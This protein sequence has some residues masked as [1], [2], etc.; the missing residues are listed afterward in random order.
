MPKR[1]ELTLSKRTVDRLSV[2]GKDAVFWDRVL[3]GFGVRVYP[4]GRKIYVV[5]TRGAGGLKRVSLGRHG[6]LTAERARKEAAA[7]IDRIKL[8]GKPEAAP[9][10]RPLTVADLAERY[11]EAHVAANCNAHT[12]GIYRGSLDN[13][14]LPALGNVPIASV[15]RSQ[16]AGFH[17][18]LR[19]TPRAANRALMVLSKMFSLA[20]AWGLAPPGGNP[21]RYVR[22]YKEGKRERFLTEDEYRRI[23]RA[24]C[25]LEAGGPLQARAASALRL[26]MVTGCR[27][28]EI[29]TLRWDDVDRKAGELRLRDAK[30]GARMVP[31][32]PTAEAVLAGIVRVPGSPWVFPGKGPDGH[33]SQ[34]TTYWHRAR[35]LAGVEDVRIHDL[36]HS[37]ASRALA[38]G[39]SLSMIGRLLGHT[40][41]GSTARYAHLAQD[42]EKTAVS[43]VGGSIEA[44]ILRLK[45]AAGDDAFSRDEAA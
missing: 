34:L 26:L 2:E 45:T 14:I 30:T 3:A 41:V 10:E 37:F 31:L 35:E 20:E 23:G 38:L 4:S 9:P 33:L 27:L 11:M 43:K 22:R 8:G 19:D 42:A 13:H 6:P 25:V 24:L 44:D 1:A 7:V 18:A 17:Y 15:S 39:E 40:D 16:A 21:C 29:L 12:Q 32:T 28:G 5:Q 36:R